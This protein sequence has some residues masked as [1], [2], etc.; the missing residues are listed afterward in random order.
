MD[1]ARLA[2]LTT[3]EQDGRLRGR[4]L[5]SALGEAIEGS[6][7]AYLALFE[8]S[9]GLGRDAVLR[10]G[11][12][13][14]EQIDRWA[15]ALVP[16]LEGVAGA[17]GQPPELIGALNARTEVLR[18]G[19]CSIVAR[20]DGPD[21]PW[22]AQ[23]WDWYEGAGDRCVV[24][25]AAF[26]GGGRVVTMTEAGILAKLGVNDRGLAVGLALLEHRRDGGPVGVPIHVILRVL[27]ERCATVEDAASAIADTQT[28]ASSAIAVVDADGGGAVFELSPAGHA[29][30]APRDGLLAHTNSF[31]DAGLADGEDFDE[32]DDARGRLERLERSA[33]R[34]LDGARA[35][36]ADH[37]G[38]PDAICRHG[39][40]GRE[41]GL[42]PSATAVSLLFE[43][44]AR[45]VH[46]AAGPPCDHEFAVYEA[47]PV[48][49]EAVS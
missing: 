16:E 20:V 39:A 18:A 21:G 4:V 46:V 15:P 32:L 29:R 42:P 34:T 13:A 3:T 9:R 38:W 8:A 23:N 44:A 31:L 6:I 36:L 17:S 35:L 45:R 12:Q 26:A 37:T 33:P 47:A 43:P 40:P 41:E 25:D 19:G 2:E 1:D 28:S 5:G 30:L 24:W 49:E 11:E 48:V 22:L 14:L 10:L 27:L 7:A